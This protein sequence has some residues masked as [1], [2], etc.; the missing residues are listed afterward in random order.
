[1]TH[2]NPGPDR[3]ADGRFQVLASERHFAGKIV[4][5]RVDTVTMPGGG[6]AHREIVDHLAA[7]GVVALD[8]DGSVVLIEQYRHPLRR[9][10]WELPAGLMDIDGESPLGCAQ[11]ELQEEVGLAAESWSVLVDLAT[12]PG[13]CTEAIR[14]FLATGLSAIDAPDAADEEADL[15]VIRL[16]LGG[17]VAAVADGRI[18]NATAVAGIL[19]AARAVNASV[20]PHQGLRPADGAW[21]DSQALSNAAQVVGSAPELA[22]AAWQAGDRRRA[23]A[24]GSVN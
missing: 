1:M 7:V 11:R 17:A 4:T 10:L 19:A 15:R 22:G 9:R 24:P 2:P 3:D 16:P 6:S 5:V 8:E 20:D 23:G 14:V 21:G 13:Y 12:S 18:V